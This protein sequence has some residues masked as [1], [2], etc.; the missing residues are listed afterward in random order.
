MEGGG[1]EKKRFEIRR[2][3]ISDKSK[4]F[5]EL[6]Q[7]LS[8]FE[9]ISKNGENHMI[10]VIED[11][12]NKKIIA[13]ACLFIEMK[14]IRNCGKAGHIEDVLDLWDVTNSFCDEKN[15]GFYVK[16]GFQQKGI[17]MSMYFN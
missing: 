16:C 9:E 13:T 2:L 3:E 10:Y 5:I 1:K 4:G 6:L 12:E 15:V 14:F 7:Q 11:E 17:E 8:R